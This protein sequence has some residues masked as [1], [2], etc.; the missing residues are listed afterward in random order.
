M[1]SQNKL[2]FAGKRNLTPRP[3]CPILTNQSGYESLARNN[4]SIG[5]INSLTLPERPRTT[6]NFNR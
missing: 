2:I 3:F 1:F 4:L 6:R 5:R